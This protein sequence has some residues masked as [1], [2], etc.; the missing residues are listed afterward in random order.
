MLVRHAGQGDVNG[1]ETRWNFDGYAWANGTVLST[2]D[3]DDALGNFGPGVFDVAN[4]IQFMFVP[5]PGA[6]AFLTIASVAFSRRRM[7]EDP[8]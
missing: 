5:A 4:R 8:R 1:Q 7:R 3:V 2:G 6:L